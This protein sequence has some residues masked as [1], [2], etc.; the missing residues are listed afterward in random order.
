MH[1][2]VAIVDLHIAHGTHGYFHRPVIILQTHIARYA[3]K[4]DIFR[5]RGEVERPGDL[6]SSQLVRIQLERTVQPREFHVGARRFERDRLRDTLQLHTLLEFAFELQASLHVRYRD[7]IEP[8]SNVHI[9][10]D[11][12]NANRAP[13]LTDFHRTGHFFHRRV[14]S[15]RRDVNIA[16]APGNTHVPAMRSDGHR[17][18]AGYRNVEISFHR[19]ISRTIRFRVHRDQAADARDYRLGLIVVLVGIRLV[20]RANSLTDYHCDLVVVRGMHTDCTACVDDFQAGS[21][22]K[23]LLQMIVEVVGVAVE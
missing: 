7:F 5:P 23:N 13:I 22:R 2:A 17:S 20:L 12:L 16:V 1:R 10:G 18:F 15:L 19:V 14:G 3:I 4:T 8:I 6:V 11:L 21:R 9:A